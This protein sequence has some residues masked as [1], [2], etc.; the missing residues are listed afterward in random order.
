MKRRVSDDRRLHGCPWRV[1][2][3]ALALCATTGCLGPIYRPQSPE[4]SLDLP[5]TPNVTLVSEYTHPHGLNYV[6]IESV[7]VVTG[8]AG[9]GSDPPPTSQRAMLLDEM[10]RRDVNRPNEVLA[11]P[12]TSL[13]L[14][15]AF[16]RP[17]IQAGDRFD[18]E[19]RV[20]SRSETTSLRGGWLLSTRLTEMAMLGE[21]VR[22][23]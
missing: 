23:G 15:R 6:K 4:A 3:I 9:T 7:S 21:N 16:L 12:N 13:V 18:V 20:P 2:W 8:L 1:R 19:V 14:I 5:P 11:S 22:T 17:G 10:N